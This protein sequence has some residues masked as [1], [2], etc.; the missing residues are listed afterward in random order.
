[1]ATPR[2]GVVLDVP[3]G[4]LHPHERNPRKIT[5]GRMEQLKASLEAE[6]EMM[7]ARPLIALPDGTVIAGN[8]RLLAA[9]ELGWAKI[10]VVYA[11]LDEERA[12][13]WMLRDNQGYADEV[14]DQVAALLAELN[15]GGRDLV[16]TGFDTTDLDRLLRQTGP[17]ID[18]DVAPDPPAKPKSKPGTI[19]E[20]GP[21][22]LMCG[23]STDAE[24]VGLLLKGAE[25]KVLL[26][27]PPYGI[28]LDMEWRDRAGLNGLGRAETS[29]MIMGD[30]HSGDV[31]A[32]WS[33]AFALVPSPTCGTRARMDRKSKLV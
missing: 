4:R 32:D 30:G 25:P 15:A 12:I 13:E 9:R 29:Y 22:R 31:R 8:H 28:E 33:E 17:A 21:H 23:D 7:N 16:L 10:K 19:Y 11:D 27:D 6:A 3:I 18:P 2:T 5:A 26:T 20:L 14:D 24:S 1:M